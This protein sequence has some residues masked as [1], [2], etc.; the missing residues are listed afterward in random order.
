VYTFPFNDFLT[1]YAPELTTNDG[2]TLTV[3]LL[4]P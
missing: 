2:D 4:N 1:G 3:T